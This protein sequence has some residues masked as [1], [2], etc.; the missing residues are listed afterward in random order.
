MPLVLLPQP[1]L[2]HLGWTT[3]RYRSIPSLCLLCI[4]NIL[5]TTSP[6]GL[7]IFS[8][9]ASTTYPIITP[10]QWTKLLA[11]RAEVHLE[12]PQRQSVAI[13]ITNLRKPC[14]AS[15]PRSGLFFPDLFWIL[16]WKVNDSVL[17]LVRRGVVIMESHFQVITHPVLC[18]TA[19]RSY[20]CERCNGFGTPP[21]ALL[22]FL[23]LP[24]E[25][26]RSYCK[27]H[28][29]ETRQICCLFELAIAGV[30]VQIRT[31]AMVCIAKVF[32][33]KQIRS[34]AGYLNFKLS[35]MIKP[36]LDIRGIMG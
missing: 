6:F 26:I 13:P 36:T 11:V 33:C 31:A 29:A 7:P 27:V 19:R 14:S 18:S 22:G 4:N 2:R 5:V 8:V 16:E 17:F 3:R 21:C 20:C 23:H 9:W 1:R 24:D 30:S 34:S 10:P 28:Q 12:D 32:Y 15:L 25:I 35:R